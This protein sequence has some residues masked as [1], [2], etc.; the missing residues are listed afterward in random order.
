MVW[1]LVMLVIALMVAGPAQATFPGENGRLAYTWSRGG[2]AFESGPRAKLVGVVSV[3]PNGRDRRL[4][5]RDA[6]SPG[7]APDGHRIAFRRRGRLWVARADGSSSVPITP[8]GWL[9]GDYVWSPRGNR[10]AFTRGFEG[11]VRGVLYTVAPDGGGVQ[12]VARA[13]SPIILHDDAWSPGGGGIVYEQSS[14]RPLVR[15]V[16][17]GRV[18]TLAR[19]AGSPTWSRRGLIAYET[20]VVGDTLGQV[21]VRRGTP[22]AEARCIRFADASATNPQWSPDGHRMMVEH[23]PRA[24]GPPELWT[25]R[26]DGTVLARAPTSDYLSAIFSPNGRSLA[27]NLL[28]FAGPERLHYTDLFVQGLDG[29]G[30]RLLVRGGQARSPDWQPLPRR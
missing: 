9:V 21:C 30:R 7:Y 4:V 16:R 18:T 3:R 10:I 27:F 6:T 14:S 26:P 13:P 20:P 23:T 12:P 8:R 15:I 29:T 19:P 2:E 17:G 24:G 28:R 11:S 1:A 25:L 5:A 22:A